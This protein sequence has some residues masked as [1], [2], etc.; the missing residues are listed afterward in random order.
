MNPSPQQSQAGSATTP[1]RRAEYTR[2]SLPRRHTAKGR[3]HSAKLQRARSSKHRLRLAYFGFAALWGFFVGIGGLVVAL[4]A[5]G[6]PLRVNV[7]HGVLAVAGAGLSLA[8]GAVT[9]V[10]YREARW[11]GSA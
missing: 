9:A 4:S 1:E 5:S 7:V 11:R 10:A 3:R 2:N 8:G 6:F